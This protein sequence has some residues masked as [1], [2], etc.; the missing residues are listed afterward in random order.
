[1]LQI[2][3]GDVFLKQV[4]QLP[5]TAQLQSMEFPEVLAR[6]EVTGHKHQI[7]GNIDLARFTD[8]DGRAYLVLEQA[9]LLTHEEHGQAEVPAGVYEVII[10]RD[11]DPS[12][13]ERKVVD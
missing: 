8:H 9:G 7:V 13:Y 12:E 2:R 1:M 10:E 3:N 6:G 11:Y 4:D 5:N